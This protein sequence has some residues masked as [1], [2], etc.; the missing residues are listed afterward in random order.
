M[1][2]AP[3]PEIMFVMPYKDPF[4]TSEFPIAQGSRNRGSY[5]TVV[6]TQALVDSY[7]AIDGKPID[8]SSIYDPKNPF[9]NRD[10]RLLASIVT[11]Q[12]KWAGIIFDGHPDSLIFRLRRW[13]HRRCKPGFENSFL[14][15][16]ILWIS[17]EKIY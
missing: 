16:C 2:V 17:L 10:P 15:R 1:Q 5:S 8:E 7:E 9:D 12:S 4:S 11:P 3:R 13:F 14:A 6:P